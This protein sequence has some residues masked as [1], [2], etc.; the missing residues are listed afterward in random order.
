[1]TVSKQVL[2]GRERARVAVAQISP[3]F[4]DLEASVARA[5]DT[6]AEAGAQGADL[7]VF[8]EAW[9]AGYPYWTEGWDTALPDWAGARIRFRDAA[10]VVGGDTTDRLGQ[11]A[12]THGV[13]LVMGCNE[14]DDEAGVSTIYNTLLYFDRAGNYLGRH[15]KLMPTFTERMFWGYGRAE[16]L[17]AFDTDIGRIGGLICGEH[18]MPLVRAGMMALGEDVHVAAFPGSFSLH[19]GPRLEEPDRAG[20]F[21]GHASVRNHA[22]ESGCFTVSA[23]AYV[24]PADVPEDFPFAGRMNIDYAHGGSSVIGPLGVPLVEP[25]F[26]S[27][28]V[29]ADCEAWMIKAVKAI[30]DTAGHYSRQDVVRLQ[31]RTGAG[32]QT[33]PP[34]GRLPEA[35]LRRERDLR[36]AAERHEVEADRVVE[37]AEGLRGETG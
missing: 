23:C 16:D 6:I 3:V 22:F 36:R 7:V 33:W 29:Y 19:E 15:R 34:A 18:L 31:V 28:I 8:P 12:R 35:A 21:W 1:M 5:E 9:L 4:L 14:L 24:D 25:V 26:G 10:V 37:L 2:G 32:W 30:V 11:A 13:N 20:N 17:R 27:Q